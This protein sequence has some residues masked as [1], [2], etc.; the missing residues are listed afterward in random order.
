M[1]SG[2]IAVEDRVVWVGDPS[3][4]APGSSFKAREVTRTQV[5]ID[6]IHGTY[7]QR[8]N[9]LEW[10]KRG[11]E[12]VSCREAQRRGIEPWASSMPNP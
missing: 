8:L 4:V 7:Q 11:T 9:D 3:V 2:H 1:R 5:A 6:P 10:Y 12:I